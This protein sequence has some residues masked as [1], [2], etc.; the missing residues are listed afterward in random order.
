M[1]LTQPP[2]NMLSHACSIQPARRAFGPPALVPAPAASSSPVVSMSNVMHVIE[3]TE[4]DLRVALGVERWVAQVSES[5]PFGS[6]DH[7]LQ[8]AHSA[9]TPLSPSEIDEALAHHPRIGEKPKGNGAAQSFSRQ[10]QTAHDATD[11][12]LA[13]A[14]T[15]GN[16]AYE[17]K[18]GRIF[19]IRAAG[20][21]RADV[22]SELRRRLELDPDS[23]L[24]EVG[25]Q[26][27]DIAL[28]RLTALF[29][30]EL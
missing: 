28:L 23:E 15:A 2:D 19:L 5:G 22:L 16:A 1:T 13:A 14:I 21:S 3:T 12:R 18:F 24:V 27:R 11:E 8:T 20:R 9:A 25:E 30:E 6:L 7:L 26:L 10:E 4:A 29:E 17:A